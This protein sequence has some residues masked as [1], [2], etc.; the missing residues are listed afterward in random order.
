M[1]SSAL[2]GVPLSHMRHMSWAWT[3]EI[4][5]QV[6]AAH[7]SVENFMVVVCVA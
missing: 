2:P 3:K 4:V 5:H 7:H 6:V 1:I